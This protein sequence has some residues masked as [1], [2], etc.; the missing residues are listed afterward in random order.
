[1]KKHANRSRDDVTVQDVEV[2]VLLAFEADVMELRRGRG[3]AE[4]AERRKS[5]F[6]A[7]GGSSTNSEEVREEERMKR[8]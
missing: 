6:E 2:V 7:E 4:S 3:R 1:M 8:G 5:R